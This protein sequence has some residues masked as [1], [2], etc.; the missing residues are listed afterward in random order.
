MMSITPLQYVLV[1]YSSNKIRKTQNEYLIIVFQ[2]L[3]CSREY[4]ANFLIF[5]YLLFIPLGF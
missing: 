5:G 3:I 4:K 2:N 1:D